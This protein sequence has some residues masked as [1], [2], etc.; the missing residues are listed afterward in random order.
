VALLVA[1]ARA[2]RARVVG[3]RLRHVGVGGGLGGRGRTR[4]PGPGAGAG[5]G[6]G[7]PDGAAPAAAARVL[8]APLLPRLAAG[9]V[10]LLPLAV[11]CWFIF[12]DVDPNTQTIDDVI[13]RTSLP[14]YLA[15]AGYLAYTFLAEALFART[16]GK[17]LLGLRVASL[18]GSPPGAVAAFARNALR[19]IDVTMLGLPLLLVLLSPL[20]QRVGDIAARTVVVSGK[21]D[22]KAGD[23]SKDDDRETDASS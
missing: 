4:R 16:V 14:F 8:P 7:G 20:R 21:P 9:L 12:R 5:A 3:S 19:L 1:L 13:N 23:V 18:D 22:A 11:A 2:A 6:A 15:L 10:D 17:A